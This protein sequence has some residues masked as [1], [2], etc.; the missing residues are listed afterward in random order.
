MAGSGE[1][2]S[3]QVERVTYHS[4]ETGFF[5][6]RVLNEKRRD[7]VAVVGSAPRIQPGEWLQAEG[8][9][10]VDRQHGRQ[11]RA[12]V[13][14]LAP[15]SSLE[16]I[17]K[18]LASGLIKGIGP[19]CARRLVARFGTKVFEILDHYS[20]R[21][22]EVP[23]I[24]PER[25]ARLKAAWEEQKSVRAI[26]VFLHSHG[27]GT[28]RAMRIYQIYGDEA[29]AVIRANPFRLAADIPG[30]GFKTAD[31]LAARLGIGSDDSFRLQAGL[32]HALVM[33]SQQGHCA[34]P[35]PRLVR[36]AG[37]L[38]GAEPARW[39]E[40]LEALRAGG[41][42]EMELVRGEQWVFLPNLRA[43]ERE[44]AQ[45][46]TRLVETGP[47]L[48]GIE[49]ETCG[50]SGED[51]VALA[52]GQVEAVRLSLTRR[53]AII[54]GGPGVGKTTVLKS[55]VRVASRVGIP[56]T[57]TAPTG[58]AA[59]R[60]QEATGQMAFTI[61]RLLGGRRDEA[62]VAAWPQGP[63]LVV[64]DEVS[65]VDVL[66]MARL[67]R[68]V[69]ADAH[70]VL[71]G[72]PNQLPSVGP[73]AVLR[74]LLDSRRLPVAQLNEVFR[75]AASSRIVTNAYRILQGNQPEVGGKGEATDFY[76]IERTEPEKIADA[77]V[78][79]VS[80][81]V[82]AKFGLDPRTGIQ[83][84]TPMNR[85]VLGTHELNRRLQQALNPPG[86]GRKQVERFGQVF[87]VGDKVMQTHNNYDKEVFN[88]DIGTV[89]SVDEVHGELVTEFEGRE[90]RFDLDELYDLHLAYAVTIHKSQ[91]SEYPAVI[92]PL[93][94][95]QFPL[96][97]RN[98]LYTAVTRGKKLVVVVGD[99]KA[100]GLC[101]RNET[102]T[103][104]FTALRDR[105][106]EA[107]P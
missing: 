21:L 10:Q 32:R 93:A 17:E 96:L 55:L 99:P 3:G 87:R 5:V 4:E 54:T 43:A 92:I 52:K 100:I 105:L 23:G 16:G 101:L 50:L 86:D 76:V 38:L 67:L 1:L 28:S 46:L 15:P 48:P 70:L 31:Q 65:M 91:G 94:T 103:T 25:R 22:E 47:R 34:L 9:W 41:E 73:G 8:Q 13:V 106:V 51:G 95:A 104:R 7:P 49:L 63:Q 24:G 36:K 2:L 39:Q 35:L 30:I 53:V 79:L 102:A 33:A 59:K 60:L 27:M 82:P 61:H 83:V 29:I 69:P 84:L 75:Q 66:L 71:V 6:A 14:R 62:A 107:L 12:E 19:T 72:D 57:L 89:T 58:R 78:D 90:V 26:M 64:V 56:V 81:R 18:Y 68:A 85:G 44:V 88:G 37:T 11:F 98:L 42:V 97:Q 74:D 40:A 77:V 45:T 80:H 20:K